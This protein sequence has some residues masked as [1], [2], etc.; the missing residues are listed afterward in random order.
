[1]AEERTMQLDDGARVAVVG[2]GPAGSMF[3][4]FLLQMARRMGIELNVDIYEPRDFSRPGPAGC[5]NCGGII[6]EW[7]VQALAMEGINLPS[8]VVQRGLES[9]SMHLDAGSVKIETPHQEKRIATVHRGGGPRDVK[10]SAWGSFD[11]HVFAMA[12]EAGGNWV[13]NKVVELKYGDDCIEVT[14]NNE[15]PIDYDL[16]VMA[17]GKRTQALKML[18]QLDIGFKPP[19]MAK[20]YISE[21]HMGHEEISKQLGN[22]MHLFLPDIP[23]VK[24]GALI[25]KGDYVTFCMLGNKISN[26]AVSAFIN[27]PEVR[28]CMP[29]DWV[30]PEKMCHCSPG[31]AIKGATKP[32]ADRL[33]CVGDCSVSR[34]Y[35]DGIGAAY[36]AA[37]A[38]AVAVVHEGVSEAA[39]EKH[40][41][42]TLRNIANDNNY[43]KFIF[44]V[45]KLVQKVPMIRR[46]VLR[47]VRRE[48]A[49]PEKPQRMSEVLWDTF[50]GSAPYKDVFMRTLNPLF[51]LQFGWDILAG[52]FTFKSN[53]RSLAHEGG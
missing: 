4:Y 11:A 43:G 29:K 7:L 25:P 17:T 34:L 52:I 24:F 40:Y 13:R 1:M 12:R 53:K 18:A 45:T 38:A 3:C 30:V 9:Y 32:Y 27:L 22:S 47:M 10:E 42:P 28:G 20:A 33:L 39:L 46:G 35:K 15:D 8:K 6:S 36:R 51:F 16:V 48:Q 41:W 21:I 19:V 26:E 50:T 14:P 37:K 31:L 5:N 23:N 49:H 44:E 2:A